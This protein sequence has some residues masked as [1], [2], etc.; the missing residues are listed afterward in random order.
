MA[1]EFKVVVSGSSGISGIAFDQGRLYV[2]SSRDGRVFVEDQGRLSVW[3]NTSGSP[4]G[5]TSGPSHNIY[6]ADIAHGAVL[7]LNNEGGATVV[8]NEYESSPLRVRA[9]AARADGNRHAVLLHLSR[10]LPL[11]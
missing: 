6:V 9:A 4:S 1:A 11:T 5:I 10:T 7:Q 2:T 8:V 3:M